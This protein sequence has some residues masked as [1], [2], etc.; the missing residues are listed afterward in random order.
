MGIELIFNN[1]DDFKDSVFDIREAE[2][3]VL[4]NAIEASVEFRGSEQYW[5]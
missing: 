4:K 1:N 2:L 3:F 5:R